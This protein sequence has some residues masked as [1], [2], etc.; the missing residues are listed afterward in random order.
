MRKKS[1][2]LKEWGQS[3]NLLKSLVIESVVNYG[4]FIQ[5]PPSGIMQLLKNEVELYILLMERSLRH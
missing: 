2:Y 1:V 5:W 3:E 4:I